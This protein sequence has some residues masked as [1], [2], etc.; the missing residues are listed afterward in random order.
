M[1]RESDS[2]EARLTIDYERICFICA[3][4]IDE[5]S[6]D[7]TEAECDCRGSMADVHHACLIKW[8]TQFPQTDPKRHL[9]MHCARPYATVLHEDGD[10]HHAEDVEVTR[11]PTCVHTVCFTFTA[12]MFL[13][14]TTH[15]VD[16]MMILHA[17]ECSS[18]FIRRCKLLIMILCNFVCMLVL[19]NRLINCVILMVTSALVSIPLNDSNLTFAAVVIAV[20]DTHLWKADMENRT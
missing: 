13:L 20:V 14:C 8:R 7:A 12:C 1:L 5:E 15:I 16:N 4:S 2:E 17:N 9:C 11:S 18:T 10:D 3:D 6:A 19:S